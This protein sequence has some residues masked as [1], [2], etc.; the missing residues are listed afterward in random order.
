M[1]NVVETFAVDD[2]VEFTAF[3]GDLNVVGSLI[4]TLRAAHCVH[5]GCVVLEKNVVELL[6]CKLT[7]NLIANF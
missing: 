5:I 4:T 1:E 3:T 2:V 6:V 7:V